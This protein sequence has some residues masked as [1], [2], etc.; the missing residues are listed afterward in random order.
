MHSVLLVSS[1]RLVREAVRALIEGVADFQVIGETDNG[2]QTLRILTSLRPDL[3]LFDLDPDYETG[4]ETIKEIVKDHPG[5]KIIALSGHGEGAIVKRALHS[6][7]R[8]YMSKAGPSADI[9]EVLKI[10][11]RGGAYLSPNVAT[12]VMDWV[13]NAK[14]ELNPALKSLTDREKQVL[15]LVAEGKGSKE[16]ATALNLGVET[17]RTYRKILMQKVDVHNVAELIKFAIVSGVIAIPTAKDG[18]GEGFSE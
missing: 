11:A 8:G 18:A 16:I 7:V 9:G 3:I 2:I 15:R 5:I 6:G 1:L 12:H 13:K 17:I 10:V 4:L 14:S